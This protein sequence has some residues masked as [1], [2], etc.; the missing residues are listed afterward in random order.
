MRTFWAY[1]SLKS[2]HVPLKFFQR[3]EIGSFSC[4]LNLLHCS[5]WLIVGNVGLNC[6]VKDERFLT[7]KAES[8]SEVMQIVIL[9]IDTFDKDFS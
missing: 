3:I 5:L 4:F 6:L 2:K 9:H 7:H 1:N 8:F